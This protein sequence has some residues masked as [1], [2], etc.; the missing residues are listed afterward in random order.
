MKLA[1]IL[2]VALLLFAVVRPVSAA[3]EASPLDF[4]MESLD[5]KPVDLSKYKGKVVL[6]VNVASKCG[7]TPQYKQLEEVYTKYKGKGFEVLGFPANEF[8]KQEP[9]TNT[10]ISTFC[11][12]Q[13]RRRLPDVLQDRGQG[14]RDRSALQVPDL[15][16][17]RASTATSS[18]TSR[19][20]WSTA[21]A[22]WSS[23]VRTQGQ[24]RRPGSDLGHRS[25]VGQ[26]VATFA[27]GALKRRV[28]TGPLAWFILGRRAFA[29]RPAPFFVFQ[30]VPF[31]DARS[32]APSARRVRCPRGAV[33]RPERGEALV[34]V[35]RIG[36]C[37][38]DLHAFAGRQ[39]FFEYPRILGHELG[40]EVVEVVPGEA[41]SPVTAGRP[42]RDRALRPL[43]S[44]PGLPRG[45]YNCC[46][47]LLCWGVHTDGGMREF[48][49]V[50]LELLHKSESLSLDQLALVET[51]GIGAHAV[52]RSGL[53]EGETALVV[54]A[55]P[56][57][58][59]TLQFA[60][61]TGGQVT[62][63]EPNPV[64]RA[65]AGRFGV[66]TRGEPDDALFDVV[67]DATGN[68]ASMAASLARRRSWRAAGVRGAG[69]GDGGDRRSDVPSPR[70]DAAGQPQQ[71]PR[72]SAASS[73]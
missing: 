1:A 5:G 73:A 11:T 68:A 64:R 34:R 69:A 56:I 17:D 37:G 9:G 7:L 65:F 61:L 27:A 63:L 32:R 16:G 25:R 4:K 33:P 41:A 58:L 30:R 29:G 43:R 14:R 31:H 21:T 13:V 59:A 15:G 6:I 12:S 8:G 44:L 35:R 28:V 42:L 2:S 62:V 66:A 36:V 46:Q 45:R 38:T 53:A 22:R 51:L 20:S 19:S 54:G 49:R 39:P 48:V 23:E 24:A 57:G 10:E 18:G 70:G 50:P 67:F 26:E 55:G 60:Q 72:V 52:A 3:G 71:L 40:V 47:T